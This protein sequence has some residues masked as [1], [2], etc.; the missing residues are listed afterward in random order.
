MTKSP[1]LAERKSEERWAIAFA[2]SQ[3]ELAE[4]AQEALA[5]YRAGRTQ[6]F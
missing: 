2:S 6:P 5:D 4:L 3:D 1:E